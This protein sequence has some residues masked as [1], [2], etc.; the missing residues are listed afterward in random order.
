MRAI[1]FK[2]QQKMKK[3]EIAN[4]MI[5][6]I[7]AIFILIVLL[8]YSPYFSKR[9]ISLG[10]QDMIIRS[11]SINEP[12]NN[13]EIT[14]NLSVI[15]ASGS[16]ERAIVIE[17]NVSD[18]AIVNINSISHGGKFNLFS[19]K[20]RWIII[21]S[22]GLSNITLS[23]NISF[24]KP[25]SYI[26]SG[27]YIFETETIDPTRL[28]LI[29]GKDQ[30]DVSLC[31]PS[32]ER[33]RNQY[34]DSDNDGVLDLWDRCPGINTIGAQINN[35]G[36]P[37]P[38]S[39]SFDI[40]PDFNNTD[41][42]NISNFEIGIS[43]YGRIK[44][45][46]NLSLLRRINEVYSS[47]N[48]SYAVNISKA[49][50][51]INSSI[52]SELN[53]SASITLVNLNITRPVIKR[54]GM[55]CTDCIISYWNSSEGKIVF[56][57]PHFT[58]YQVEEQLSQTSQDTEPDTNLDS[59]GNS[60]GNS[61]GNNIC[62]SSWNCSWSYCINNIQRYICNDIN[63]CSIQSGKPIETSRICNE[64]SLNEN[65]NSKDLDQKE[66]P[67]GDRINNFISESKNFLYAE[68][69]S[70]IIIIILIILVVIVILII[71][72]LIIKLN[73]N[74]KY[75]IPKEDKFSQAKLIVKEWR[76]KGMN[77]EIIKKMFRDKGWKEE[78]INSI[79]G[80]E[81]FK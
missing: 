17:E 59:G 80:L 30:L 5:W 42:Y 18:D 47:I 20:I 1:K 55:N 4:S 62:S 13:E 12:Y 66:T 79:F 65:S 41:L 15:L 69:N 3:A 48:L 14:V 64:T 63:K 51:E 8:L 57:V 53:V 7:I 46:Q 28:G 34:S 76:Q 61:L 81:Y 44:F 67:F 58:V 43:R 74:R 37:I 27:N 6:T 71:F 21:D 25:K 49:S 75:F 78:E 33:C 54:D 29:G 77:E 73:R 32:E 24:T 60:W 45:N 26:F 38:S 16:I 22:N 36:C 2:G 10:P 70:K 40:K 11:L 52:F 19:K 50:I 39:D 31:V 56:T 9:Y 23:Y 68:E 35:F 72:I